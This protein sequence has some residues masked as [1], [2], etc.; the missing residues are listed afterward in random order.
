MGSGLWGFRSWD[1]S[2]GPR[3]GVRIKYRMKVKNRF[4]VRIRLKLWFGLVRVT[5]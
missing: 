5:Y 4:S 2:S 1:S 3:S